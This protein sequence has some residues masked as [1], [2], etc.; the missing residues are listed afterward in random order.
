MDLKKEIMAEIKAEGLDAIEDVLAKFAK[1]GFSISKKYAMHLAVRKPMLA[2]LAPLITVVEAPI[3]G[4][5]DK[6]DGE[7]D[8]GR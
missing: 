7:D 5:I 3:M 8:E 6:L 4:F 2:I 1:I